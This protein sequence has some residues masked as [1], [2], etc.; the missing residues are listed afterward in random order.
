[1]KNSINPKARDENLVVQELP[2]ETLI[3]DLKT[4]EAHCL[5]ETA[6]RVWKY[7]DGKTPVT[8]MAKLLERSFGN[9]V[10]EDIVRLAVNL[11]DQKN[12]LSEKNRFD[13]PNRRDVIKKIGLA[14]M[15]ALPIVA[16]LTAPT[17]V[18]A[19]TANCA[20][21]N[22]GDCPAQFGCPNLNNCNGSGI[23]AP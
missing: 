14:S 16:T 1:M 13:L 18:F 4:N 6:A 5:N 12:L 3:Y 15:V 7:C 2:T 20:C 23:C 9:P 19:A 22:P 8:D 17:S 10:E 21:V 11:L